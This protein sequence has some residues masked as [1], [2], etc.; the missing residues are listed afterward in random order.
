MAVYDVIVLG[1]GVMGSAAM[2]ALSARGARVCGIEQFG[3][4]HDR[5]SSHGQFRVIRRAY[6]EHPDYMPLLDRAYERWREMDNEGGE[7]LFVRHPVVMSAPP[8]SAVIAGLEATYGAHALPHERIDGVTA[9][10]R[11]GALR[12]PDD[13]AVFVDPE[14]GYL[15]VESSVARFQ[16]RARRQGAALRFETRVTDWSADE[17]GVSVVCDGERIHGEALVVTAGAWGAPLLAELGCAPRIDAR[18]QVWAVPDRLEGLDTGACPIYFVVSDEG[19][20]YGFPLID[21]AMMKIAEH[22]NPRPLADAWDLVHYDGTADTDACMTAMHRLF[23]GHRFST[24]RTSRCMYTLT[25]DEH[26]VL[27]VH[28]EKSNV[29]LGLGFSGHGFKFAPAVGE[30]LAELALDGAARSPLG[31]FAAT[32]FQK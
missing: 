16:E 12:L 20:F 1:L 7:S 14:G 3:P 17:S 31:L 6:F 22:G 19:V 21:G 4:V 2:D 8:D 10:Q 24:G 29:I 30:A 28:P 13:H 32:R 18:V 25:P 5:G 26:F 27:D 11:F 15:H 9:N 23:P